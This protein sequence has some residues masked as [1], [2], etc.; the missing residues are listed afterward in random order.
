VSA[1]LVAPDVSLRV[2]GVDVSYGRIRAVQGAS[3][4]LRRGTI[5]ALV[6]ANGAGK[7]SLLKA[8]AGVVPVDTGRVVLDGERDVTG[9]PA[10][11]RVRELGIVLIPEG[12]AVFGEMTV[13]ENLSVGARVGR[14]RGQP[15]RRTDVFELFPVLEERRSFQARYLSGGE[16][17]MLAIGRALL[18]DPAFLLVDEPSMGLAPLVVRT[19]FRT[20]RSVL[21]ERQITVLL[22][23]QD[24]ELALGIA[25]YAYV[26][27]RGRIETA[28]TAAELRS[29]R[30][31]QEAY[32]G[33]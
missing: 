7:S 32:L 14:H 1:D 20:L 2:E 30:R 33:G 17:Q 3:L 19:I 6:G 24:S 11:V 9:L 13:D 10:H 12:H 16:Q 28:G 23:E 15:D 18:M 27:E 25:N 5:S 31:L 26:I 21:E 22:V 4:E 29:D 8:I